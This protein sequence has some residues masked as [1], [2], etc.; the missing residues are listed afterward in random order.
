MEQ[1]VLVGCEKATTLYCTSCIFQLLDGLKFN[2]DIIQNGK[3]KGAT[4][5]EIYSK[6]RVVVFLKDKLELW[7]SC[8]YCE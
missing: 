8:S 2:Q 4:G 6:I 7:T 3:K 1:T 5:L